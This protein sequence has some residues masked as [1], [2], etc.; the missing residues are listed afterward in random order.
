MTILLFLLVLILPMFF[1]P[2]NFKNDNWMVLNKFDIKKTHL[3][4]YT[5]DETKKRLLN[6]NLGWFFQDKCTERELTIFFLSN[7]KIQEIV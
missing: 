2:L 6:I 4:I 7:E 1:T 3:E 5:V